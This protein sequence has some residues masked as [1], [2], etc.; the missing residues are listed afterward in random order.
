MLKSIVTLF[1][2]AFKIHKILHLASC[3]TYMALFLLIISPAPSRL[4]LSHFPLARRCIIVLEFR[5]L[6]YV[7]QMFIYFASLF[8]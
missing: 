8:S 5:A 1:R 2:S 3:E 4:D 7:L 6:L